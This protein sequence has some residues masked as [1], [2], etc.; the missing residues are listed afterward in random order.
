MKRRD[1]ISLTSAGAASLLAGTSGCGGPGEITIPLAASA[2]TL[3]AP[4]PTDEYV[5]AAFSPAELRQLRRQYEY[6]LYEDFLP[7]MEKFVIDHEHGGFM[8]TD[9]KSVV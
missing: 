8:C 4:L 7:F 2:Q 5:Q 6:D 1:F 3:Q 9:R